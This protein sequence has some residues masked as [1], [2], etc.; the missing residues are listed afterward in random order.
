MSPS[1]KA[2][3]DKV[4]GDVDDIRKRV[5]DNETS[6]VDIERVVECAVLQDDAQAKFEAK[7]DLKDMEALQEELRTGL[8]ATREAHEL[9][10]G[11]VAKKASLDHASAQEELLG[12]QQSYMAQVLK[13]QEQHTEGLDKCGN[14]ITSVFAQ[15]QLLERQQE[16][17][18]QSFYAALERKAE[19]ARVEAFSTETAEFRALCQALERRMDN[20]VR[21]MGD[22]SDTLAFDRYQE[23][24]NGVRAE[25]FALEKRVS[26]LS[27]TLNGKADLKWI[28]QQHQSQMD[29][30][31]ATNAQLASVVKQQDKFQMELSSK[32]DQES[33]DLRHQESDKTQR[34]MFVPR[35]DVIWWL[36]SQREKLQEQINNLRSEFKDYKTTADANVDAQVT[37]AMEA[38]KAD[39]SSTVQ[40]QVK[41]HLNERSNELKEKKEN[42]RD[43]GHSGKITPPEEHY[44]ARQQKMQHH[45][46]QKQVEHQKEM[47]QKQ[48][49]LFQEMR[50]SVAAA[51][52]PPQ[53]QQ[54]QQGQA[55]QHWPLAT[56]PSPS[57]KRGHHKHAANEALP[58]RPE[59]SLTG[60]LAP[61]QPAGSADVVGVGAEYRPL[62][63]TRRGE[64]ASPYPTGAALGGVKPRSPLLPP[65]TGMAHKATPRRPRK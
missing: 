8:G 9:L 15:L 26:E 44:A 65:H 5:K 20:L 48:D 4:L 64:S 39:L 51:A 3:R 57:P 42:V 40:E 23:H 33:N 63:K 53:P 35:E 25:V 18:K 56:P 49:L 52:G 55:F 1:W 7:A 38:G 31:N 47:E 27:T 19:V 28:G 36:D 58:A 34:D 43:S 13:T 2:D 60:A 30:V 12:R 59:S 29:M 41:K 16:Q 61:L 24:V 6:L 17:L 62:S 32:V 10:V 22:K 11:E 21:S 14:Q 45:L 54:D 37:A 46:Q 50:E